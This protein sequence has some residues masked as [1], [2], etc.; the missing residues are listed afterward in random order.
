MV[1]DVSEKGIASIF[2]VE[3][4]HSSKTLVNLI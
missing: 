1:I 3:V 2:R 4:I